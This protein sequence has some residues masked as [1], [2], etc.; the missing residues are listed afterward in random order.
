MSIFLVQCLFRERFEGYLSYGRICAI[1]GKISPFPEDDTQTPC[2]TL[3]HRATVKIGELLRFE[4]L[5]VPDGVRSGVA[6]VQLRLEDSD[7]RVIQVFPQE[8]IDETCFGAITYVVSTVELEGN[9]ILRPVLTVNGK[10][11]ANFHPVRI[12]PT[13]SWNYKMVR[14]S[15][16]DMMAAERNCVSVK[17][18]GGKRYAFSADL[19]FG[20][21]LSSVELIA[22]EKEKSAALL[23]GEYD[24]RRNNLIRLAFT[25]PRPDIVRNAEFSMRVHGATGCVWNP[26]WIANVNHG[27]A[28]A[29]SNGNGVKVTAG[30][31]SEE[32]AYCV[33][34]PKSA[35]SEA[36]IEVAFLNMPESR[37]AR[38][39][40]KTVLER[41]VFAFNPRADHPLRID[42]RRMDDLPDL[43]PWI[44]RKDCMWGGEVVVDTPSPVFHFRAI[45][46]SGRVWR[47]KP[48]CTVDS[49]VEMIEI[50]VWNEFARAPAKGKTPASLVPEIDYVFSPDSCAALANGWANVY[51]GQLGGGFPSDQAFRSSTRKTPPGSRTPQWVQNDG[52]WCL[53]FDGTNDY[54]NLPR[55]AF[56]Q[57]AFTLEMEVKPDI[58]NSRNMVLFRHFGRLRGSLSLFVREGKLFATWGSKDLKHDGVF[59]TGL[60]V[61]DGEWNAISVS[62][63]FNRIVFRVD[64]R[65][66]ALPWRGRAYAFMPAVFG[67]HDA[68]E[69]TGGRDRP[70][71]F[72]GLLRHLAIK[73]R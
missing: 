27:A 28:E 62:Y 42:A 5:N 12:D 20:E 73:H 43:P 21:K 35:S 61:R 65:E 29:I 25:T 7:G 26:V 39:P 30:L 58:G 10:E 49:S 69:L 22:G 48:V 46:Q 13:V 4:M 71:W 33:Q 57:A 51:S 47:S 59:E 11:Y 2:L 72:K 53:Y 38:I 14:Q 66:K 60:E 8:R 40:V 55:E 34:I 70:S 50:P 15:L 31:W 67:G 19:A 18:C 64:G 36:V 54:V 52:V 16:R 3:S 24:L 45:S 68:L 6:S 23:E 17:H 1:G 63:D 44:G 9:S 37:P 56:P 41:G 32:V